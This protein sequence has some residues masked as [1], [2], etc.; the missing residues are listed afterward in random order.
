MIPLLDRGGVKI[1]PLEE[2]PLIA[3][4]YREDGKFSP[5][6]LDI[7]QDTDFAALSEDFDFVIVYYMEFADS[8]DKLSN[9][10]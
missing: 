4:C 9:E 3:V 2:I 7:G 1:A 5:D 6:G 8:Y 10:I